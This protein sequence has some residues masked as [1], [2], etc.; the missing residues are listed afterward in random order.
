MEE[1]LTAEGKRAAVSYDGRCVV[2]AHHRFSG[3]GAGTQSIPLGQVSSI[4]W[5]DAGR[6][7]PGFV[8][9]TLAGGI[10]YGCSVAFSRTQQPAF[11]R[12][13]STVEQAIAAR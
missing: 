4:R 9:F 11:E 12:V 8:Q 10:E 13:K 7:T 5:R 6:L 2:I 1:T 3:H